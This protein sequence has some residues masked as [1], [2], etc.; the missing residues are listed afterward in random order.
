MRATFGK[1][2][3]HSGWLGRAVL[4]GLVG[5]FAAGAFNDASAQTSIEKRRA[6]RANSPFNLNAGPNAVLQG[7]LVQCGINNEGDVCTD[8]FDSPTGGGGFW[9]SGTTNQYIFNSG[10]QIAG[11]NGA[12]AGPWA[13]DTVGAYFFDARG[14]QPHGTPIT[15][16]FNSLN[17]TDL[18]NWPA[19]AYATDTTLFNSALVGS[20]TISDQ[21]SWVTYWDGDPNRISQRSHPAGIRVEQRSLAFNA[22]AGA[23]NTIF[24]I[25][26]FTNVTNDPAFQ[27]ANE[28]RF[29]VQ[30][31]DA[32]WTIGNLYAAFAMDPDVTT[33]A[34]DNYSTAILPFNMGIAYHGSFVTDDFNYAE[35]ASL[36]APPFFQGPGFVGV[37]YLRSP[38]DPATGREVGLTMFSNTTNGGTFPDP[39]GVKQLFRYLKGDTKTAAGDPSCTITNSIE[40]RLCALVQAAADTRFYQASGPFQLGPG[41]SSTIVVAYTHGAPLRVPEYTP[42]T[43]LPPGIPSR[44]PGLGGPSS[45]RTVEKMAGLIQVPASAI[46]TDAGGNQFVDETKLLVGRDVAPRS[47]LANALVAQTIFN[48]KFLLPRPPEAPAFSL[49]PGNN[50]VT[51]I[52]EPSR[53]EQTGDPYYAIASDPTS[54]LYNPNYRQHD[55]EGYR[56]YRATGLGGGFELVAQFDKTGT[57]FRDFTGELDPDFVP[58]EGD[59]YGAPVDHALSGSIVQFGEGGRIRNGVTGSVFVSQADTVELEDTGVPFVFVDRSVRNGIT[60]RYIVTAFDVNSLKS[61]AASLESP[62]TP[63]FTVPRSTGMAGAAAAAAVSLRGATKDLDPNAPVPTIDAAGRFSGPQPP[64]NGLRTTDIQIALGDAVIPGQLVIARIDSVI[65]LTYDVQYHLT[66]NGTEK[67]VLQSPHANH[68][69]SAVRSGGQSDQLIESIATLPADTMALTGKF[70]NTPKFAGSVGWE[71]VTGRPPLFSGMADWAGVTGQ[72]AAF[73]SPAAPNGVAGGSRWFEG[74]NETMEHPT[75]NTTDHG[76]LAGITAFSLFTP[77]VNYGAIGRRWYQAF[78][79]V[80]RAADIQVTW[81][82]GQVTKVHDVTHDVPVPFH[83]RPQASYGFVPDSDGNGVL[84]FEDLRRLDFQDGFTGFK[85]TTSPDVPLVQ[86]PVVMSIDH[87]NDGAADGNGFAMYINGEPYFFVGA[88]PAN[89]TW[90]YRSYNG[91]VTRTANGYT[92]ASAGIRMPAVPGLTLAFVVESAA[93][94]AT[95]TDLSKVHTVPDPYYVRSAFDLGPSNKGLRFV[96][97]PSQ[98]IV[99]IYSLNGTLVRVLTHNDIQGGGELQWDLRN[100]NNQFVASG[101]YFYVVEA[102][103]G[104][105]KTGRFTVVQF[106]R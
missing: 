63:Q 45:I 17:P 97:L 55:V 1:L 35:R 67:L 76:R 22:P 32:G 9:P 47:L 93:Q 87:N 64:T 96:N 80:G 19:E 10:L 75:A 91:T 104:E 59:P 51:V 81:S 20:A 34:G 50:Q 38:I 14:T 48:N 65:P 27:Q 16:V 84:N 83:A 12:D 89:A 74:A 98:A 57:V 41:Q 95:N 69:L 13:N 36:Y 24:F 25:Y 33:H 77:Y 49:V 79:T 7:N 46:G 54:A 23:E 82:N 71:L 72:G 70:S 37:K 85:I 90:T 68:E 21:D 92:F 88:P 94:L 60:Y 56:V 18:A 15:N 103:N 39:V 28:Q 53:S 8:V 30:L 11:I 6:M 99:R 78:F 100:R 106:A 62:R 102:P 2:H 52:W 5:V 73:W 31:P 86:Q 26:R 105:T 44:T 43:S 4:A 61:G 3:R 29:N 101:V 40:Q 42:G 58:E 66:V